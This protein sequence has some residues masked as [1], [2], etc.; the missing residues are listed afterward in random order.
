VDADKLCN[1]TWFFG[2]KS[3][4]VISCLRDMKT[5][6]SKNCKQ[7]LFKVMLE[8]RIEGL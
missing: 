6:V 2:Y 5:Q 8:V 3:G 4:Q 7:Q 1:V